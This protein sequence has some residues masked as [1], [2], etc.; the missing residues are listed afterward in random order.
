MKQTIQNIIVS[1]IAAA[2]IG[3]FLYYGQFKLAAIIIMVAIAGYIVLQFLTFANN[4]WVQNENMI[5]IIT[6]LMA[7]QQTNNLKNEQMYFNRMTYLQDV[8]LQVKPEVAHAINNIPEAPP[9]PPPNQRF[10]DFPAV[11]GVPVEMYK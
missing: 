9:E 10:M 1:L 2:I 4:Q 7:N 8:L 3:G 6:S 5:K 11:D